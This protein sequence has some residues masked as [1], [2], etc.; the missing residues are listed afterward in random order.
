MRRSTGSV[1]ATFARARPAESA[2]TAST[3][4]IAAPAAATK[5][6][7]IA[8]FRDGRGGFRTC[9][10]SRVKHGVRGP[11]T[12]RNA[13]KSAQ[14]VVSLSSRRWARYGPIRLGLAQRMAQRPAPPRP[15]EA[16]HCARDDRDRNRSA[17]GSCLP[18]SRARRTRSTAAADGV[19]LRVLDAS[20]SR[21]MIAGSSRQPITSAT[22]C[23]RRG[24][25]LPILGLQAL[26]G[27]PLA[28]S[29]H[30]APT[31]AGRGRRR[32]RLPRAAHAADAR[33]DSAGAAGHRRQVQHR[34]RRQH[35]HP[36]P[37][38]LGRA[39]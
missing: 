6:L 36:H 3:G 22:A 20:L 35:S 23:S 1:S 33:A 32:R 19:S 17:C 31:S 24:A 5:F 21:R 14:T 9:D 26:P 15:R 18:V 11:S 37:A 27:R 12:R 2:L 38:R 39:A 13:C 30:R 8:A 29:S 10:L 16:M 7:R 25:S 34:R 4:Q 28:L